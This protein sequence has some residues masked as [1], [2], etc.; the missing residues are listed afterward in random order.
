MSR[1]SG[2]SAAVVAALL[3]TVGCIS[4]ERAPAT[5]TTVSVDVGADALADVAPADADVDAVSDVIPETTLD[6][7][8]GGLDIPE[9]LTCDACTASE[10]PCKGSG[11]D[12]STGKCVESDKANNTPCEFAPCVSGVCLDGEC[13]IAAGAADGV[14][15]PPNGS[16]AEDADCGGPC[17]FGE[18]DKT[19]CM[20][21]SISPLPVSG[22]CAVQSDCGPCQECDFG[23]NECT[24][25]AG[26][27]VADSNC[28]DGDSCT[29]DKCVSA[30]CVSIAIE[31]CGEFKC[32]T[33]GLIPTHQAAESQ[34]GTVVKIGGAVGLG[35]VG[36]EQPPSG[37]PSKVSI[38]HVLVK[39]G[40]ESVALN[41]SAVPWQCST[42]DELSVNCAE[43]V[44][45]KSYWFE[46]TVASNPQGPIIDVGEN[47]WCV[48]VSKAGLEG[49]YTG[50]LEGGLPGGFAV[51]PLS[52]TLKDNGGGLDATVEWGSAPL[53]YDVAFMFSWNSMNGAINVTANFTQGGS[54]AGTLTFQLTSQGNT[55]SGPTTSVDG[56][57]FKPGDLILN[58]AP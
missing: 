42:C 56:A 41:H 30:T 3:S 58:V 21:S 14:V 15:A 29:N 17:Q 5:D 37:C 57:N 22:C 18:C 47:S 44:S 33:Q 34:V 53:S 28:D 40:E 11:C 36:L 26:C 52:M 31:P 6:S 27:C 46:G 55:L 23:S 43:P 32:N 20:C 25:T 4:L 24:V 10:N 2:L 16:C 48:A 35:N 1:V 51:Y 38:A 7:D 39:A 19:L 9:V 50:T 54:S 13:S 12:S 8:I 49:N 45:G